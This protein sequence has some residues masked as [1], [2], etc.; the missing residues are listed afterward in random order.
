VLSVQIL[1]WNRIYLVKFSSNF[2]SAVFS[3]RSVGLSV[4]A[5]DS[6]RGRSWPARGSRH[7]SLCLRPLG[8]RVLPDSILA[9]AHL[10][11]LATGA[12][13]GQQRS[14]PAARLSSKYGSADPARNLGLLLHSSW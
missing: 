4:L 10:W 12:D 9:A 14:H 1:G 8:S 7:G 11:D 13:P 2:E 5:A 3:V 6:E